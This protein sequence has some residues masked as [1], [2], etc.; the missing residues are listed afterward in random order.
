MKKITFLIIVILMSLNT[1]YLFAQPTMET[2]QQAKNKTTVR[3][4]YEEVLN[5]GNFSIADQFI[6]PDYTGVRGEKGSGGFTETIKPVRA[7][8][9]DIKW[10]VEDLI[11]EDNKVVIRWS[12]VG[13]NGSSFNGFP[14]TN[15]EVT[16]TAIAIYEF[17]GDRIIK[18]WMQSDRLGFFQ[19]IGVLKVEQTNPPQRK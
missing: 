14:V 18:A 2:N 8:F 1:A 15:K 11:A 9:P 3:R 17:K 13:T 4:L 19:Q 7:A 12:W 5:T 10:T 16:Q 6:D